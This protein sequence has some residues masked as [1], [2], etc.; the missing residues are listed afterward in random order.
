MAPEMVPGMF[1]RFYHS[2]SAG[3]T[4]RQRVGLGLAIARAIAHWLDGDLTD[5]ARESGGS[6]FRLSI[7]FQADFPAQSGENSQTTPG[8]A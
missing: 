4:G 5:R 7:R 3:L 1:E 2:E 8:Q 6:E